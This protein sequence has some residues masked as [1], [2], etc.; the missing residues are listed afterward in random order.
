MG[1]PPADLYLLNEPDVVVRA[2]LAELGKRS[3]SAKAPPAAKA[4]E[5]PAA[6]GPIIEVGMVAQR[7][8]AAAGNRAVTLLRTPLSWGGQMWHFRGPMD[9]IGFD[10]GAGIG[11]GPGMAVGAALALRGSGRLPI[12]L[13]GHGAYL[14]KAQSPWNAPH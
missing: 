5:A 11:S 1:L 13:V 8:R 4:A 6:E 9:Y 12:A 2:L 3:V 10:G 14:M 7:L